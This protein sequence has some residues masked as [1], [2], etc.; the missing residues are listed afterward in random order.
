M[1]IREK[2]KAIL[3]AISVHSVHPRGKFWPLLSR[4]NQCNIAG[5]PVPGTLLLGKINQLSG[6]RPKGLE[7][8]TC[9]G[10]VSF[11]YGGLSVHKADDVVQPDINAPLPSICVLWYL[12]SLPAYSESQIYIVCI[13]Y[14]V[15]TVLVH[16]LVDPA[17]SV[18]VVYVVYLSA[19]PIMDPHSPG[20]ISLTVPIQVFCIIEISSWEI[21]ARNLVSV[22]IQMKMS[23]L[24]ALLEIW[25]IDYR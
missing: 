2:A 20:A 11:R 10:K 24:L 14:T 6:I 8:E 9:S 5:C 25:N 12:C 13:E 23:R 4:S 16:S 1:R 21:S 18:Q 17:L 3:T 15:C 7:F 22:S 19:H